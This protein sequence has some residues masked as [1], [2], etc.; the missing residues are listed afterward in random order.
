M[1]LRWWFL[2]VRQRHLLCGQSAWNS[3][4]GERRNLSASVSAGITLVAIIIDEKLLCC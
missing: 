4:A 1:P 2:I 3:K